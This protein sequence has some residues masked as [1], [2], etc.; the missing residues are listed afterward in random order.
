[1]TKEPTFPE[2]DSIATAASLRAM[3]DRLEAGTLKL[4]KC[5]LYTDG[6]AAFDFVMSGYAVAVPALGKSS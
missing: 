4:T 3:A 6:T 1:M 5:R 2:P